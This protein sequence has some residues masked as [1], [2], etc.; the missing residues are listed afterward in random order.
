VG[1]ESE[2]HL[3]DDLRYRKLKALQQAMDHEFFGLAIDELRREMAD[4]IADEMDPV[5]AGALRAERFALSSLQGR[6]T[7]YLNELMMTER[8]TN[9]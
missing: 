5:K 1:R 9:G 2:F 6:L 8:Q 4:R 7:S 3:M